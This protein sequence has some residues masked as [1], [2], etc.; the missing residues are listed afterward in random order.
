MFKTATSGRETHKNEWLWLWSV[1]PSTALK[2]QDFSV[3]AQKLFFSLDEFLP[4]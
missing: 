3:P 2:E 4:V 1:I